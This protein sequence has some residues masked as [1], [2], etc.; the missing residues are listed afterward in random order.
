M[1]G[2][3]Y[4]SRKLRLEPSQLN[5]GVENGRFCPQGTGTPVFQRP[6]PFSSEL[7]AGFEPTAFGFH[8]KHR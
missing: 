2:R 8:Q 4:A 6:P 5:T 7:E 1:D 3:I